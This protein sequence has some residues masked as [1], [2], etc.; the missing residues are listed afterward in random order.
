M[1]TYIIPANNDELMKCSILLFHVELLFFRLHILMQPTSHGCSLSKLSLLFC[2]YENM[3]KPDP[4]LG[5]G[6][7]S[8]KNYLRYFLWHYQSF[9]VD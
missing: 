4:L 3:S 1:Y 9:C 8:E 5:G 2:N 6:K 7:M